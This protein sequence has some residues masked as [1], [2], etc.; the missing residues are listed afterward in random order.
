MLRG[1]A[2]RYGTG[3]N[4]PRPTDLLSYILTG[5]TLS[6][7]EE[8]QIRLDTSICLSIYL[9]MT[10]NILGSNPAEADV[11]RGRSTSAM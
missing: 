9:G 2:R 3:Q 7:P 5:D 4:T 8:G 6:V 10:P 1:L 11:C